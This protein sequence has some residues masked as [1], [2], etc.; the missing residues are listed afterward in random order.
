MYQNDYDNRGKWVRWTRRTQPYSC[1]E[2]TFD[3]Q[4]PA[5]YYLAA[6]IQTPTGVHQFTV[7]IECLF[8]ERNPFAALSVVQISRAASPCLIS[9]D[10]GHNPLTQ[11][12]LDLKKLVKQLSRI[13]LMHDI[14]ANPGPEDCHLLNFFPPIRA[15]ADL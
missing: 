10:E 9:E 14:E 15:K 1:Q 7:E 6:S 2:I 5:G 8:F 11:S 4:T 3:G 13:A 12:K